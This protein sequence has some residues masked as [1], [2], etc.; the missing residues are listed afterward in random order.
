MDKFAG[1]C[2][3]EPLVM[4]YYCVNENVASVQEFIEIEN[5]ALR[6]VA[7]RDYRLFKTFDTQ[8]EYIFIG[9]N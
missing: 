4:V 8:I 7:K 2:R 9:K 5:I 3:Q 6:H 1:Y